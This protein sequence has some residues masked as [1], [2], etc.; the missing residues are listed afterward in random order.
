LYKAGKK[1]EAIALGE[2]AVQ[3]G[4]ADKADTTNFEKRLAEMKSGKT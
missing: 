2:Q 1:Q 4:K 3:K